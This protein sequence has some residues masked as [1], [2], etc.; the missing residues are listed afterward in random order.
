M[1]PLKKLDRHRYIDT[2]RVFRLR[3]S[4]QLAGKC[5]RD[6]TLICDSSVQFMSFVCLIF[7]TK[8]GYKTTYG[9][10]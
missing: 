8:M 7:V 2:V 1:I 4:R 9:E 10:T 6:E 3:N 5:G